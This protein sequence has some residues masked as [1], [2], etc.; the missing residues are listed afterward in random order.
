MVEDLNSWL[1][2][3]NP[4]GGQSGTWTRGLRIASPALIISDD[5]TTRDLIL[6]WGN[7]W[8]WPLPSGVKPRGVL[9]YISQIGMC[10]PKG[11]GL[12][13]FLVWK[14]VY[15]LPTLAGIRYGF[16]E[17]YGSVWAYLSFHFQMNKKEIE[18]CEFECIW[19]NFLFA[20]WSK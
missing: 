15:T 19:Q 4:A 1:P 16:R 7:I 17:N 18:I 10:R 8:L 13:A 11:W 6:I 9:P 5:F 12:G 2:W 3:T 20:L 14:R